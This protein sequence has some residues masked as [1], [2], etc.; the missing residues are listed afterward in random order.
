MVSIDL[1]LN[2]VVAG[3]L[4]GGFY[5]AVSLGISVVFGL[6]DIAN[7]AHPLFVITGSYF[8]FYLNSN[9]GLDPILVGLILMPLFFVIGNI[10]YQ[11]YYHFFEKQGAEPLRGL[12][13]FFGVLFLIEVSIII[14]FGVDYQLVEAAYLGESL[15][16]GIVN[17]SYRLFIPFLV[18]V[19]LTTGLHFFFAKT[20][21]GRAIMGVSQDSLALSLMGADPV[22]IKSV[23]FGIG[24]ATAS[25]A[26]ALLVM[27]LPI[28]PALGREYIGRVFAVA[29]LG[30]LGSVKGALFAA[31]ILGIAESLTA[32][33]FGAAWSS[34]VSFGFLLLVLAVRPAGLFGR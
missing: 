7:I 34:G 28:E 20:F 21:Y 31:I 23:A 18:G 6:L 9:F 17:V 24:I 4:I 19:L 33:Y 5:A 16:L 11:S 14:T 13:F 30:G 8:T 3:I 15:N 2:A 1:L 26:G 22:R 29:V 27:I 25:M 32:T 10:V 12:V